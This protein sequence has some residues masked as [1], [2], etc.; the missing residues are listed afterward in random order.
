MLETPS[1]GGAVQVLVVQYCINAD[2]VS[3]ATFNYTNYAIQCGDLYRK[4]L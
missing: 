3:G 1:Q 4:L 2:I